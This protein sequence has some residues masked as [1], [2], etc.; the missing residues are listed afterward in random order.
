MVYKKLRKNLVKMISKWFYITVVAYRY[1]AP[2]FLFPL[3][4][5]KLNHD[6]TEFTAIKQGA[7]P[8][9]RTSQDQKSLLSVQATS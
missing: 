6:P 3:R 8:N 1:Y 2:V 4:R 9:Q 5:K 7:V